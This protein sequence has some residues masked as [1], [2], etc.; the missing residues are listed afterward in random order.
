MQ[1]DAIDWGDFPTSLLAGGTF[2]TVISAGM[3]LR[4]ERKRDQK[5]VEVERRAQASLVSAWTEA[6]SDTAHNP[7]LPNYIVNALVY[8]GSDQSIYK[9]DIAWCRGN[10][11]DRTDS[12]ALIPPKGKHLL[13][14]TT[15]EFCK[16]LDQEEN[17][18]ALTSVNASKVAESLRIEI[19]FTDTRNQRW[20]RGRDGL[21]IDVTATKK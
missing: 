16:V 2:L 6:I 21:L 3:I 10:K 14:I 20:I 15:A 1:F 17:A 18:S 5:R 12:V 19:T 7:R 4:I 13:R 9:I 11:I 8:N